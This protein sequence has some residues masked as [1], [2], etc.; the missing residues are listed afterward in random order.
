MKR[1]FVLVISLLSV[2]IC[3]N[4]CFAKTDTFSTTQ[5]NLSIKIL[6]ENHRFEVTE[7]WRLP[8][9]ANEKNEIQ[10]YLSPKMEK[11]E[12]ET[13]EPKMSVS[14]ASLSG[15]EESGDMKWTLKL[16]QAIP[17]GQSILLRFSYFGRL[18]RQS[19]KFSDEIKRSKSVRV[20]LILVGKFLLRLIRSFSTLI[21]KCCVG[22]QSSISNKLIFN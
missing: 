1:F 19:I 9:S 6:P 12:V 21:T 11:P 2:S 10:F 4:H 5:Y 13:I 7:T 14:P 18:V 17:A 22:W 15:V 20:K 3:V 16:D 8:T